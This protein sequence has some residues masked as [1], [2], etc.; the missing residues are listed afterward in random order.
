EDVVASALGQLDAAV[1]KT[2]AGLVSDNAGWWRTFW[3]RGA[4]SLHSADGVADYVAQ[5][6][7]YYLYLMASTSRGTFP[8]KFNGMIWNT[9]GD[10]RTWGAQHW[11]A[12]LSCYYEALFS[13]N[14]LDL[15]DPVFAMYSGMFD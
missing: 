6:Y 14:R 9:A 11:F 10:L 12:N 8:P 15:L 13:A 2:F 7:H 3:E 1:V 4:V 5:H